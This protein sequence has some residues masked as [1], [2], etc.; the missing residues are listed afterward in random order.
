MSIFESIHFGVP[1]IGIPLFGDQHLNVNRA[2]DKGLGKRVDLDNQIA[3]HLKAA[4]VEIL[5]DDRY[6]VF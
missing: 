2:V 1:I 6:K 4:I 5:G 3:I